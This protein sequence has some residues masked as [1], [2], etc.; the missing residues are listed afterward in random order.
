[1]MSGDG[2][3]GLG[4]RAVL[5]GL[6]GTAGLTMASRSAWAFPT[7]PIT[8]VV[9]YAP[10]STDQFAR[11]FGTEMEK[12]LGK[13]ILV[14]TRPGAGGTIGAN[15]V[16]KSAKPDGHT[17]LFS[18]SAPLSVAPHQ[19]QLP[20]A[21][22]DLRPVARVGLGPNVMGARVGAPFNDVKSLVAYAKANPEKVT[23]GSAG[24]GGGTHLSGEAFALAAGIKLTHVP[25]PGATPAVSATVGGT[26][27]LALG[28]AQSIVPQANGGRMVAIAQFGRTRAKILPDVPTFAESG[29]NFALSPLVGIWAPKDTPEA[30][31]QQIAAAVEKASSGPAVLA[32]AQSTM[33]EVEFAGP[34]VFAREVA[35]E[36][37]LMKPL[38]VQLGLAK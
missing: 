30:V 29:V 37:A 31:V 8:F 1:M 33:T 17:L 38:L 27:D 25:F 7:Q 19:T 4:R 2:Q 9:P 20:Y 5:G 23:F 28:F 14:E 36:S 26:I 18:T 12:T 15:Y 24:A 16:A 32:F 34:D 6:I 21:V 13:T 11:A 35:E 10:G 3:A 22:S